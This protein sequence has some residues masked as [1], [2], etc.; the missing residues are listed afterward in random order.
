M[1]RTS[2]DPRVPMLTL[3]PQSKLHPDQADAA[4][5]EPTDPMR[6]SHF[7]SLL[8]HLDKASAIFQFWLVI[9]I[10]LLL[11]CLTIFH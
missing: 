11:Q 10:T 7:R 2:T 6:L 5:T 4:P 3:C 9:F 1:A 8:S